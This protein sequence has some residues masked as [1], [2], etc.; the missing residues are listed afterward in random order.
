MTETRSA[1]SRSRRTAAPPDA[2]AYA[3]AGTTETRSR[4]R[5]EL[6]SRRSAPEPEPAAAPLPSPAEVAGYSDD[7]L[8]DL[9]EGLGVDI[10]DETM[11]M[12]EIEQQVLAEIASRSA[13]TRSEARRA[14]R[15]TESPELEEATRQGAAALASRRGQSPPQDHGPDPEDVA[16]S[17]SRRGAPAPEPAAPARGR[18]RGA[19]A[20]A[21]EEPSEKLVARKGFEG[22]KLTRAATSSFADDFKLT[23]E[24]VL[25]KFLQDEPFATYGEHG[26]YRQLNDGQ[27]VWN[28][29]KEF[30]LDCPICDRGH[31]CRAV[32]LWNVVVTGGDGVPQSQI[33]KAGPALE[34]I[35]EAKG[36]ARTG[37]LSQHYYSMAQSDPN[38]NDGPVQYFVE[39]V[40]EG[41]VA[42]EWK[43][44]PFTEDELTEFEPDMKDENYVEFPT[45]RQ[46]TDV[47]RKMVLKSE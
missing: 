6:P 21:P 38:D 32:A 41:D 37:P 8:L 35:L 10:S 40:R 33:L 31:K 39:L 24:E 16:P 9:A 26:L 45:M 7:E 36:A 19:P 46:L 13:P 27:R 14:R 22:Y 1:P 47:A 18:G 12:E 4:G 17:R 3:A 5:G 42:T 20:Q 30:G 11:P 23:T 25:V 44:L 43:F 15:A 28:C 34:K 29:V 2:D